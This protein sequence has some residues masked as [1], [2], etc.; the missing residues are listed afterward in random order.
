MARKG[1]YFI[2][3]DVP[4]DEPRP[5]KFFSFEDRQATVIGAVEKT[6]DW[7]NNPGFAVSPDRRW[8]LYS[9]LESTEGD[10]MLVD[11]AR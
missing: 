11:N 6:V 4:K 3:F 2:D 1:I 5:V 10:L 7:R 8:L 9:T